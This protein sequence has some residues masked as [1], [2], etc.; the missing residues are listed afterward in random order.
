MDK[1]KTSP[2]DFFLWAGAMIALY[3]S[4]FSLLEL[5]FDYID[6]AYP[7]ALNTYFDPYSAQIRVA[8]ASLIVLFPVFLVLMRLIRSDIAHDPSKKNLWV[9]KWALVLTVF[10]AGV[11][12]IVDLITLINTFLGGELTTHFI[13]KV[14]VVFLVTGAG[15][16]HFLADM[17][18]YWDL[19]P[20]YARSVGIAV[21]VLVVATVLSGF[22]IIGTPGQL[23]NYRFDDQKVSDLES[24][25]SQI[26]NYWQ[27]EQKLPTTLTDLND[28]ISGFNVPLDSQTGAS[29]EYA[30]TSALSFELCA[31]FNAPTQP[32]SPTVSSTPMIPV[33]NGI[34]G[35]N[36]STE[37][38]YHA[39]GRTC[40]SRSIDPKRYAPIKSPNTVP[41]IPVK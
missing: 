4:V 29:Y 14:L 31:T 16:L 39:A 35:Y 15:L 13:L 21:S 18:G 6:V 25:Q 22:L 12:L 2:K 41:A 3:V 24:I 27:T 19:N 8:I 9:R 40:F 7:D 10:V 33:Y 23:R 34:T 37:T 5:F 32:G 30:T 17:W 20:R 36:L 28:S 38:W 26:V 11:T 1:P